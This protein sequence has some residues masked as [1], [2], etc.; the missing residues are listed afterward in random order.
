MWWHF[1]WIRQMHEHLVP[2]SAGA[3]KSIIEAKK[4]LRNKQTRANTELHLTCNTN[5][6]QLFVCY[7]PW[8]I[9]L[10]STINQCGSVELW[11]SLHS[12]FSRKRVKRDTGMIILYPVWNWFITTESTPYRT[13][14]SGAGAAVVQDTWYASAFQ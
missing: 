14:S 10:Q 13:M 1:K 12:S 7:L 4:C 3:I 11:C 9:P 2:P 6:H 5:H 8:I